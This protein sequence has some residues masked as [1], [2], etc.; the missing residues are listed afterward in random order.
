MGKQV[1]MALLVSKVQLGLMDKLA[2]RVKLV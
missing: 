2:Y 1:L